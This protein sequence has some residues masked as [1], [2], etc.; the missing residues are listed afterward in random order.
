[1]GLATLV[2]PQANCTWQAAMTGQQ[3]CTPAPTEKP[4]F[5]CWWVQAK[6][7]GQCALWQGPDRLQKVWWQKVQMAMGCA[8][9]IFMKFMPGS[10][11]IGNENKYKSQNYR[12]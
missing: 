1:M 8:C 10:A 4:I 3:A 2:L 6:P 5:W 11:C 9:A 7:A 12:I